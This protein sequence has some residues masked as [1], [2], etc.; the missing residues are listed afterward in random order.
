[1]NGME[2]ITLRV[3]KCSHLQVT[4][5]STSSK[6]AEVLKKSVKMA[7]IILKDLSKESMFLFF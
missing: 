7:R 1:M 2:F 5:E 6:E 3:S 4:A